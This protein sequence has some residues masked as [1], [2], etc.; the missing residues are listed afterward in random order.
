LETGLP[1]ADQANHAKLA[2]E[3]HEDDY[4]EEEDDDGPS[5]L[6]IHHHNG[7][8]TATG[9]RTKSFPILRVN[10]IGKVCEVMLIGALINSMLMIMMILLLKVSLLF[11]PFMV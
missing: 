9:R 7:S 4:D 1:P 10:Q 8:T 11:L 2:E 3:T 5:T 6:H